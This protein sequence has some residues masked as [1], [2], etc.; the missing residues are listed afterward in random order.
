MET[1]T[2]LGIK[3]GSFIFHEKKLDCLKEYAINSLKVLIL[4]IVPLLIIAAIIETSLI[5]GV[6]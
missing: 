2:P 4:I 6:G 1:F 5:F 3:L